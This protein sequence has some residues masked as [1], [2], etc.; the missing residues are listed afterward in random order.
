ML[1]QAFRAYGLNASAVAPASAELLAFGRRDCSGKEC[2]P[3]QIIWGAFRKHL[4][5]HP[6]DIETVLLQVTGEGRCRTCMYSIKDQMT[7][8]R[9][10]FP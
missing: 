7:I 3:Y 8:S 4:Q 6:T 9:M 10:G 1:T 5:D 2:L